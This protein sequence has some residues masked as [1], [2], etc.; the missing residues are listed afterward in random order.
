MSKYIATCLNC[1]ERLTAINADAH[2]CQREKVKVEKAECLRC[3]AKVSPFT[4]VT[5]SHYEDI[6][7]GCASDITGRKI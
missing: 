5:V 4:L 7:R 6:C 2:K 3:G 1:N